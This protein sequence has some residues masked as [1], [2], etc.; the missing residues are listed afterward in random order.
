[1]CVVSVRGKDLWVSSF[2][3]GQNGESDRVQEGRCSEVCSSAHSRE[4]ERESEKKNPDERVLEVKIRQLKLILL[5]I[6][7]GFFFST[8][9]YNVLIFHLNNTILMNYRVT[10]FY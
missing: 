7:K 2:K 1:M 3:G 6:P 9:F 8:E 4:Q 5:I 10:Y